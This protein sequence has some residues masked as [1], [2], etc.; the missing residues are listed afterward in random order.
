MLEAS[1]SKDSILVSFLFFVVFEY[2]RCEYVLLYAKKH[3]D[4]AFVLENGYAR[5]WTVRRMINPSNLLQTKDLQ[6]HDNGVDA[7]RDYR[8]VRDEHKRKLFMLRWYLA[9]GSLLIYH[10]LS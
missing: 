4:S 8:L 6:R 5:H 7:A 3:Y 9:L 10:G 2:V 1:K